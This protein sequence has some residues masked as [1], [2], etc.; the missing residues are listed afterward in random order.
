M[1]LTKRMLDILLEN[2]EI[3]EEQYNE[4]IKVFEFEQ[5]TD[6]EQEII[7]KVKDIK[8]ALEVMSKIVPR[9]NN[10]PILQNILFEVDN[11]ELVLM[12]TDLEYFCKYR[13]SCISNAKAKFCINFKE[14]YNIVKMKKGEIK[15]K[16][17]EKVKVM[18][19][20][21]EYEIECVN[22]D[23]FPLMPDIKIDICKKY[24]FTE[25]YRQSLKSLARYT[26]TDKEAYRL[27][28]QGIFHTDGFLVGTNGHFMK[29][30]RINATFDD[31]VVPARIVKIIDKLALDHILVNKE[32]KY[33]AYCS[34]VVMVI[35]R[36][37]DATFPNYKVALNLEQPK[38]SYYFNSSKNKILEI[39]KESTFIIFDFE[40]NIL[41]GDNFEIKTDLPNDIDF[42]ICFNVDYLKTILADFTNPI[43]RFNSNISPVI[44]SDDDYNSIAVLMPRKI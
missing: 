1:K 40:N 23:D 14:L 30:D 32:E 7:I 34:D 41:K 13:V 17:G 20:N 39:P 35:A 3:T 8:N 43:M 33:I 12:S 21:M 27:V 44:V 24:A 15:M 25:N 31:F 9:R 16:Y 5:K 28:L 11:N 37:I 38:Y 36:L 19:D 42:K 10:L 18:A 26:A 6:G 2:N 22:S 29:I 4:C